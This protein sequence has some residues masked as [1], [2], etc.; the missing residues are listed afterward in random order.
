MR[1]K[2]VLS[3]DGSDFCG[4][5]SQPSGNSVQDAVE[6]A[7]KNLFGQKV[8]VVGS[9]RTDA[10]VHALGQVAHFDSA[11]A[12][13]ISNV[14]G[15][16]NAYLPKTVRVLSA[17]EASA[18][19]D[20]RKSAKRKTYMYLMYTG[21][22]YPVLDGR[23]VNVGDSFD[24]DAVNAA[25]QAIVGEHDFSTFMASNGGAKTFVRTVYSARAEV[26]G[27]FIAFYITANGFLYNM[28]RIIVAQLMRVGKGENV[29]MRELIEKRDRSYAKDIAPASGLY[30]HDVVYGD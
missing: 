2:I 6:R 9:G 8:T 26:N 3:Y 18:S 19:F 21:D 17:C 10:G 13:P 27:R 25:A 11:K 24:V 23:A 28:V 22:V 29:D 14:V 20:A 5:Q 7:A 30:L 4:W 1:Y 15:G 12:L 16:L